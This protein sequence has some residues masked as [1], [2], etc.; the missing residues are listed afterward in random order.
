MSRRIWSVAK[1]SFSRQKAEAV[2]SGLP[3]TL[4]AWGAGSSGDERGGWQ[5]EVAG[6]EMPTDNEVSPYWAVCTRVRLSW[7]WDDTV[8]LLGC[9]TIKSR[10]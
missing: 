5:D 3:P 7:A 1:T 2:P 6:T 9:W 4:R 8:L 10:L